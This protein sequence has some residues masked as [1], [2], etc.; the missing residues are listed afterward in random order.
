LK[1]KSILL[2]IQYLVGD[3]T[4][5][6]GDGAKIIVHVCNDIGK[7]GRGFVL[8][9]S[10]RWPEPE[11]LYKASFKSSAPPPLGDVQ[12]VAVGEDIT[13]ANVIG[14]HGI[15]LRSGGT[16]PVRY[17]AIRLGLE[18][19]AKRAA[20]QH[21]TVHMPRIG[22]GLAGGEWAEVERIITSTLVA[23]GVHVFVYDLPS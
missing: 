5:P 15:A 23:A 11:R 17:D 7:W 6:A 3:A 16:P 8:A 18:A 22:C 2:A 14:Q 9:V 21:A 12:F 13:I 4:R 20:S 1:S 10:R 19:V